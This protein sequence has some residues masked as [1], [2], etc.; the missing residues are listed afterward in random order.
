MVPEVKV[1]TITS[2]KPEKPSLEPKINAPKIVSLSA[3]Q[4]SKT[5]AI[6]EVKIKR[7]QKVVEIP[8][9]PEPKISV[10]KQNYH[11]VR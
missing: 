5:D 2:R 9:L 7:P 11:K 1:P 8:T 3:P 4:I 10:P 6:P